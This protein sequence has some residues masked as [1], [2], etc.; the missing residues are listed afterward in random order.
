MI[1]NI[2]FD[3]GDVVYI[4]NCPEYLRSISRDKEEFEFLKSITFRSDDWYKYDLGLYTNNEITEIFASKVN[5]VRQKNII[6]E[7]MNNWT[8]YLVTNEKIVSLI[9][10]LREKGYGTYVLSNSPFELTDVIKNR[11]L[12]KIFDGIVYSCNEHLNKPDKALFD[13]LLDKYDLKSEEC[14]FLD[15]REDCCKTAESIGIKAI[16]YNY[17]NHEKALEELKEIGIN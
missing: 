6:R 10:N 7:F 15:D 4:F 13:I 3:L 5:D 9:S 17:N 14:A 8:D 2:V 16:C 11:G 12:D 1:K